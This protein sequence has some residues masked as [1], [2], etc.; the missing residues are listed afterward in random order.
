[1]AI[2]EIWYSVDFKVI[3]QH[4]CQLALSETQNS[5]S[6][7]CSLF[8]AICPLT[9]E[10]RL[11]AFP[12]MIQVDTADR[13]KDIGYHIRIAAVSRGNERLVNFIADTVQ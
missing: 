4:R 13:S 11:P 1:M 6:V 10:L 3:V 8:S 5:R 2:G 12:A 7:L 9:F